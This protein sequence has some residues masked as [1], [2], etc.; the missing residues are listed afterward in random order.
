METM[1]LASNLQKKTGATP[2][3]WA[4]GAFGSLTVPATMRYSTP[5]A[6]IAAAGME[7]CHVFGDRPAVMATDVHDVAPWARYWS[8]G[9]DRPP[10]T[11]AFT[12]AA[13]P[14]TRLRRSVWWMTGDDGAV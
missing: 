1:Q 2:M 3:R 5:S 7:A 8:T 11:T 10:T 6:V 9:A 12:G 4:S 13:L 14:A